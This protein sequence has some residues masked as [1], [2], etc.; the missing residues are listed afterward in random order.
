MS[1]EIQA[2]VLLLLVLGL[3]W[4]GY[5]AL[6]GDE[7][8]SGLTVAAVQ[9][10]VKRVGGSGEETLAAPGD[11][12]LPRERI[13]AGE[14]GRAV[15]SLGP[16][17]RVTLEE[18]SALR[19]VSA[20]ESGV[21]LE[22]EGG[23]VQ[24]TIRPGSGQVGLSAD[25]RTVTTEDA[26]FTAARGEDGTFGVTTERGSVAV[27]G[28]EGATRLSAGERLV[29]APGGS[30]F[31]APASEELLLTVAWPAAARTREE[32]V[33]VRGRTEPGAKVRIGQGGAWTVVSADPKG[34]FVAR[35]PLAEGPNELKVEATSVLGEA[36][37]V[38]SSVVRDTTAPSVGVEIRY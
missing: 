36:L 2:L 13:V 32:T 14:G 25:G 4:L 15:L 8:G 12:L 6:F 33:E 16:E 22:L 30:A 18:K 19:I 27:E 24:A 31:V 7:G 20:D 9:G 38:A 17:S 26:D 21:R 1:R 37:T 29:A 5:G 10:T 23:K 34:D 28:V 11:A 3:G 35:V